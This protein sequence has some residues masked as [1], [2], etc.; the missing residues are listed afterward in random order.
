MQGGIPYIDILIFAII[1]I[2]LGL[3]LRSVLGKRTG[4]EQEYTRDP[5]ALNAIKGQAEAEQSSSD[6]DGDDV[7]ALVA[8]DPSFDEK[9]FTKGARS[10]YEIVLKAFADG[11]IETLKPLL[12][13]EMN[14]SFSD[15]IRERSRVGEVLSIDLISLDR[16]IVTAAKLRDG[17][18]SVIVE[19]TSQQK[20]L[21]KD[22]DGKLLDGADDE[23]ETFIDLWTF[24]RDI[25]SQ[26]PTW[27]L[28]ETESVQ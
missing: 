18:A 19:F 12:G 28:V 3:R 8:A 10:A 20:R 27:L 13:Y 26:D 1:A 9:A 22:E 6:I 11:D 15:A 17:L 2:F 21:L 4:F 24:E 7:A 14:A 5:E 25:S 23:T 16:A